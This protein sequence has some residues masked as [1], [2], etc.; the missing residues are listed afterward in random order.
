MTEQQPTN[1]PT[2]PTNDPD[3]APNPGEKGDQSEIT[4]TAEQQKVIDKR[5]AEAR[6]QGRSSAEIDA[7][8]QKRKADAEAEQKRQIEAG[9]FDKARQTLEAE[10]DAAN[11]RA[12]QLDA[13]IEA[14]RP[15]IDEQWKAL[16]A[17]V[18]EL[19][20]GA[21]DDVLAKRA[22]IARTRKLIDKLN[23]Q[24]EQAKGAAGFGR[25][26]TPNGNGR[27]EAEEAARKANAR[28]YQ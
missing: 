7:A 5:I 11:A 9:E 25:T 15:E 3:N 13:L 24:Q 8:E 6:R 17:E 27:S 23:A 19:Y 21:E 28:R 22:H 2:N 26:P 18:T 1:E 16:P 12:A 10:R 4:F 20:E 14:I